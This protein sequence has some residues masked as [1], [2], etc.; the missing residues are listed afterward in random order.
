MYKDDFNLPEFMNFPEFWADRT[1]SPHEIISSSASIKAFNENIQNKLSCLHALASEDEFITS[2][3]LL[4][5]IESST[6]PKK[7]MYAANGNLVTKD[8]YEQIISNTNLKKLADTSP[9]SYGLTLK[10]VSIRS[11]PTEAAVY[12]SIKDIKLNNFDRF[13]ETEVFPFEPVLILHESFDKAWYFIKAY[14]YSGWAKASDIAVSKDKNEVFEYSSAD[15]FVMI[16]G[17]EAD[18]M[19]MDKEAAAMLTNK[20]ANIMGNAIG[21]E[22]D[23]TALPSKAENKTPAIMKLGMGTKLVKAA[24]EPA[25]VSKTEAASAKIAVKIPTGSENGK[26]I[27]QT[28]YIANDHNISLGYL[29]YTRFNIAK[30]ALKYLDT[31][32]DWGGKF[33]GKDCS[34]F[35]LTIYRCFG[36]LLPRNADEQEASFIDPNSSLAFKEDE[37]EASRFHKL[38]SLKLGNPIFMNGHVTMYLGKY[39]DMHYIIHSFSGYG[40]KKGTEI[41]TRSA[42]CVAISPVDMLTGSGIP[43]VKRF[44]S[45]VKFE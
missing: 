1:N 32:Y 6:L 42:L 8:F 23:G 30:Q 17:K 34:G 45:A 41:E 3:E 31:P 22:I 11:F 12:S 44:T 19:L 36:F 38:N 33:D 24:S 20:E 27:F 9:V 15:N 10:K 26:L 21:V 35:I 39:N 43:F 18:I 5:L 29:P 37:D 16:T 13:Q 25:H 7:D 28:A 14:N 2:K 4:A 40:I